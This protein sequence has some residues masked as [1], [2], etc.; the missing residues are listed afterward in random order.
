MSEE[1]MEE[2][3]ILEEQSKHVVEEETV[4]EALNDEDGAEE[5]EGEKK[6]KKDSFLKS[7]GAAIVDEAI[8]GAASVILLYIFEG[9]LRLGGYYISQKISMSFIIFVVVSIIYYT[10]TGTKKTAGKRLLNL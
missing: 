4:E 6:Q 9:L 2:K 10:V 5:V 1:N 8:V 3:E 7:L